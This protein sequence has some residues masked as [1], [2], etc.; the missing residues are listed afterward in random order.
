MFNALLGTLMFLL[1][2]TPQDNKAE[3]LFK[4][5]L[6]SHD[7]RTADQIIQM[8]DGVYSVYCAAYMSDRAEERVKLFTRFIE[9]KPALGMMN[10]YVNRGAAYGQARQYDTAIVDLTKALEMGANKADV[11]Y[12]RG[13]VYL[14]MREY[15]KSI[16]DLSKSIER[17]KSYYLAFHMRGV[18]FLRLEKYTEAVE[19]LNRAIKLEKNFDESYTMRG[20]AYSQMKEYKKAIKDWEEAIK[21]NP[22]NQRQLEGLIQKMEEE[23]K[24]Q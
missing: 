6:D 14:G 7:D 12:F 21:I 13:E 1:S 9:L 20:I 22:G 18:A 17:D 8:N 3:E 16:A 4:R 11:Y 10:A 15:E 19:D 2:L 23:M 5:F 24:K